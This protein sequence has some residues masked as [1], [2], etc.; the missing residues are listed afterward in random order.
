MFNNISSTKLRDHMKN[1]TKNI[2][3]KKKGNQ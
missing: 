1:T 3:K 2:P